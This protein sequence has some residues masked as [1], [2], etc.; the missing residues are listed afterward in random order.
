MSFKKLLQFNLAH[1]W[2]VL[3]FFILITALAAT[4]LP[5]LRFDFSPEAMLEF[6]Q[7]EIDYQNA[8]NEKFR[9][10]PNIFLLVFSTDETLYSAEAL[11]D[12][13]DLTVQLGTL[14]G[15]T[16]SYSLALVP[17]N[18]S[19]G[20]GSLFTQHL[21]PIVPDGELT[22][23][24]VDAIRERVE[25][26]GLLKGN[27]V[28]ADGKH[29]LIM[30]NLDEA[31]SAPDDFYPVSEAAEALVSEWQKSDN[32]ASYSIDYGGLP[33]IRAV[34]VHTMK[35]EQFILWPVVGLLYLIALCVVFR[36][37]WQA[38]MPLICIG[39][40]VL[41]AIAVMVLCDMPVTMI[42]NTLP[43]LILVIG[44]TNGIYVVTRMLDERRKGKEK[45]KAISDGVYRVALA[46]LLTT[47]TTSIGFGSLLVAKT[48]I[49]NGFGGITA[50]AVM[51][52]Y[53]AIIF[54]MPQ[55]ISLIGMD[56]KG[57]Q[58]REMQVGDAP[59]G[60]TERF[61]MKLNDLAVSHKWLV[62]AGGV[63]VLAGCLAVATQIR[64]DSKV[65]DVFQE[66][67]P[68]TMTNTLIEEQLGGMLPVEVDI[69]AEEE[70]FFRNAE[71][72]HKVCMLQDTLVHT[73]GI[74]SAVSIC[75]MIEE[76]GLVMSDPENV[77]SQKGLSAVLLAVKRL[78]A[79]QY[80]S[81]VTEGGNNVHISLRIPDNGFENSKKTI[82]KIREISASA[83]ADTPVSF[84]LTGI[85]Y[86]STLGLDHFMTDLFTSLL[87]AFLIIFALLFIAFRS[88][89][90][91]VVAI[92][93]NLIPISMTLAFL[94]LYGYNLNTTS[95]LVFTISIGLA[96]DNSI[97]IISRYRQEYRGDRTVLEALR[98]AMVSSGKAILKSNVLLCSGLAVLL[99]SDFDPIRRVGVLTVTTIG[100]ALVVSMILIP[101]EIAIVGHKMKL[102]QFL[103]EEK[104]PG[105]SQGT[106]EQKDSSQAQ[107]SEA[108]N[109]AEAEAPSKEAEV[110]AVSE[111]AEA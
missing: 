75:S 18:N 65:N 78:Q 109:A 10:N 56:P 11:K 9:T 96:V 8:F 36:S 66:D 54:M 55:V 98:I 97:H 47:A 17:D 102:P 85:G 60:R 44:V 19:A 20:L 91:G 41:W 105:D 70:N 48:K 106:S 90:S 33:Y 32:N 93:P 63:L 5:K 58:E 34:T 53:V 64:F 72:L 22:A 92:L 14:E 23:E 100:A 89:W 24:Q 110:D 69:W 43:L 39:C 1:R 29:A 62:L 42:N 15:V 40:V 67:H 111:K 101:A 73:D 2:F 37:F 7:E 104:R 35:I 16:S 83:F 87:T 28:S 108:D 13:K 4:Q 68:I 103:K 107:L 61:L 76:G 95:V 46:T 26:S 94:P 74:L 82:A 21:D 81:Y 6:S 30:V 88:F 27:L 51:L 99:L 79:D 57:K 71:N 77:P 38:V 59:E 31:H 12:L 80:Y 52:I 50:F 45:M 3:G 25:G 49:L 84:R 86:N